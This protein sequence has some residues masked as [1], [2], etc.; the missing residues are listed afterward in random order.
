MKS[1]L[2]IFLAVFSLF[3]INSCNPSTDKEGANDNILATEGSEI[4]SNPLNNVYWG[5]TH[6]HTDL[7]MDAGAFGNRIGMDEAYR[8]ARGEEVISSTGLKAKLSRPLDFLVVAD[9]SDGMGLFP[10]IVEQ[11]EWIMETPEGKRWR[12][13]YDEGKNSE[14]ALDIIFNFAQGKFSFKTNDPAIMTPVWE[15]V[16]EA[17]EK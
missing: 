14:M 8:F 11:D 15:S 6:L 10:A 12:K 5:D 2:K 13:L 17:A 3:I 4:T 9:H 1:L 16:V 7:S